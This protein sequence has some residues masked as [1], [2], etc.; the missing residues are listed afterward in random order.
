M[1][2]QLSNNASPGPGRSYANPSPRTPRSSLTNG[3]LWRKVRPVF[4]AIKFSRGGTVTMADGLMKNVEETGVDEQL[5]QDGIDWCPGRVKKPFGEL[6]MSV[7]AEVA[8]PPPPPPCP[9]E[10]LS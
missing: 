8:L 4:K 3:K 10:A 2:S 6:R 9:P 7:L 5:E 1:Q